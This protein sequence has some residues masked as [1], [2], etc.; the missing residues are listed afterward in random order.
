MKFTKLAVALAF[1]PALLGAQSSSS[2][3][4]MSV[5]AAPET[6]YVK[7]TVT[8]E[9]PMGTG[10]TLSSGG[11]SW[12]TI[13]AP[14]TVTTSSGE[15]QANVTTDTSM[16]STEPAKPTLDRKISHGAKNAA[17]DASKLGKKAAHGVKEAASDVKKAV[18]GKP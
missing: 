7:G 8:G 9:I 17:K 11:S 18:T 2:S 16:P 3:S 13:P 10:F 5:R 12:Y 6:T 4:S 1:A 15:V 14:R